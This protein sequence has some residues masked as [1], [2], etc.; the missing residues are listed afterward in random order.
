[1]IVNAAGTLALSSFRWVDAGNIWSYM[2]GEPEPKQNRLSDAKWLT[3]VQ[4]TEDYFAAVHHFEDGRVQLT[5]HSYRN[6]SETISSI[7]LQIE[8]VKSD[9]V[10]M[11]GSRFTEEGSAWSFL[12]RAYVVRPFEEAF[13]LL[14]DW[15]QKATQIQSPSWYKDS[16]DMMYQGILNVT[17]IP[18]SSLLIFSIQ[19]DSEPVLFDPT[20]SKVVQK[21]ALGDRRGNPQLYF[22]RTAPELWA[23]DYD[24]LVRLDSHN[25]NLLSILKLQEGRN[26]M[27]RS[28]IGGYHFSP[29]ESLCLVARPHSG[30][31]LGIDPYTF[32]VTLRA[33][34]GGQPEDVGLLRG[35]LVVARDLKTG[36]LLQGTLQRI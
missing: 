6:I 5:A 32:T 31:V 7:E 17:E 22:R 14:I 13:L 1:M 9:N 20:T 35:G 27:V 29:D 8:D 25:W 26:G 30:D 21:L 12:P 2:L 15:S 16:Y 4:G 3:L 33:E 23:S 18:G 34:T 11:T 19:R 36:R 28:N 24:T 10:E